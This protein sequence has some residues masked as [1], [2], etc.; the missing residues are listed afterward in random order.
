MELNDKLQNNQDNNNA[1]EHGNG[2]PNIHLASPDVLGK[3]GH[4]SSFSI[5]RYLRVF[6]FV[7]C[8]A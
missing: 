4:A 8:L 7:T 5:G 6:F 1:E 2:V 3:I